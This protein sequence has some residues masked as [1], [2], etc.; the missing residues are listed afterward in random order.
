M[1]SVKAKKEEP[2]MGL[3]SGVRMFFSLLV[4]SDKVTKVTFVQGLRAFYHIYSRDST[5][6]LC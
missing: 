4:Y 3:W 5:R 6:W 1:S 2:G